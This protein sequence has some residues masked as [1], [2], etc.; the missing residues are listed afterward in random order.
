MLSVLATHLDGRGVGAGLRLH[1]IEYRPR[2]VRLARLALG[3]RATVEQADLMTCPLPPSRVA[4]LFDVLHCLPEPAQE[5]LL[6]RLQATV[7]PGG[8]LLLR[9]A[10]AGGGVG[11]AAVSVCNRL[12]GARPGALGA[13]LPLQDGGGLGRRTVA[14]RL[15]RRGGSGQPRRR[16]LRMC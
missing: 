6:A 15:R 8:F 2:M 13:P 1:G 14:I 4:I 12:I 10:D 9:E 16:R 7:E 11:F 3:G 5:R